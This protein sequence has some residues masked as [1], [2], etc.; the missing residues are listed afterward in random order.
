MHCARS[1]CSSNQAYQTA[2][3]ETEEKYAMH[4]N[5]KQRK[6]HRRDRSEVASGANRSSSL[7]CKNV[8]R[9][10]LVPPFA[11]AKGR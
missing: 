6:P 4:L 5:L 1:P 9:S 3:S 8:R 10:T 2:V 7:Q 11:H